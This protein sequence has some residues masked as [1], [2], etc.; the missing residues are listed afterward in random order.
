MSVDW[1]RLRSVTTRELINALLRDGF[2]QRWQTGSHR[3]YQHADGRR[4]SV[5][6]HG[7]GATFRQGILRNMV[8]NQ[9]RWSP[10]D[11]TRLGLY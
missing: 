6:F 9:A 10:A 4:V 2:R 8:Q 5:P 7:Y 11:L 3:R 1:S